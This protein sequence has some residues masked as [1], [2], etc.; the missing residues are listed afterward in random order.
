MHL[1]DFFCFLTGLIPV[2]ASFC[3]RTANE[4]I[5]PQWRVSPLRVVGTPPPYRPPSARRLEQRQHRTAALTLPDDVVVGILQVDP[6][7]CARLDELAIEPLREGGAVLLRDLALA[8]AVGLVA[9]ED[10]R[11]L[12]RVLDARNLVPEPL[13]PVERRAGGDRVD[14]DEALAFAANGG[15]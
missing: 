8:L 10:H 2:K 5:R 9:N 6:R 13:N 1:R 12:V 15:K 3:F 7:L 14:Q 4:N 11:D